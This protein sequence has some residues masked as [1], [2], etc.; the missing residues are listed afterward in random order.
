MFEPPHPMGCA[1][2]GKKISQ[3]S[4]RGRRRDYCD[5]TCRRRAQRKRDRERRVSGVD[6]TV[7][8]SI[9]VDLAA[10]AHEVL[11]CEGDSVPLAALLKL[12]AQVGEDA[13]CLAAAA[14]DEARAEGA[15]WPEV[16]A[17]ATMS[18]AAARA[19]W[20]GV[21]AAALLA[22]RSTETGLRAR[23]GRK[24]EAVAPFFDM[25]L[26]P[27]A[28]GN[29]RAAEAL[30][31]A[32]RTLL[33]RCGGSDEMVAEQAGLPPA[34]VNLVLQGTHVAP[35]SV[36]YVLTDLMKGDPADLRLLWE[37]AWG[38]P[39][40]TASSQNSRRLAAALRGAHL[41][42]G[43]REISTLSARVD[44]DPEELALVFAGRVVPHWAL[45]ASI[46]DQLGTGHDD[47][48]RLWAACHDA[49]D[50]RR[51]GGGAS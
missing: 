34:V 15:S 49:G 1:Y 48:R 9:A 3:D 21:K 13:L 22:S 35:W 41:A 36:I 28:A 42:A 2:C 7:R 25:A 31:K 47:F 6:R 30:A 46:L 50:G 26:H 38:R 39:T 11:A 4:P 32:L 14:V 12:A 16:A 23:R 17:A 37:R 8:R 19:R 5:P 44:A 29:R 40:T 27:A 18:E 43:G 45:L 51:E 10:R 24:G 20:G 33:L